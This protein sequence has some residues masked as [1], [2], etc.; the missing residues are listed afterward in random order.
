MNKSWLLKPETIPG[1]DW[2]ASVNKIGSETL[3]RSLLKTFFE[4]GLLDASDIVT[5]HQILDYEA[6][7]LAVH[8]LQGS[9]TIF[10]MPKFKA[11][12]KTLEQ[13]LRDND[14]EEAEHLYPAVKR[15]LKALF[16]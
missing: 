5:A 3:A 1:L 12:L 4:E 6:L 13:A 15:Q 2:Q 14:I 8:R 9:L 10:I 16:L 11:E 7:R